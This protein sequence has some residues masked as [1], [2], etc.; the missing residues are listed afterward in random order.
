MVLG[1]LLDKTQLEIHVEQDTIV[2]GLYLNINAY[3]DYL[4]LLLNPNY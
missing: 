1:H 4:T 2:V 3:L